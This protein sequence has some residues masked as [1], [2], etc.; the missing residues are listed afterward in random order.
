[1]A[2]RAEDG[3]GAAVGLL[4]ETA[5]AASR[6]RWDS[7]PPPSTVAEAVRGQ[8]VWWAAVVAAVAVPVAAYGLCRSVD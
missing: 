3:L 1:M 5:A 2:L 4:E 8:V 7:A 6:G